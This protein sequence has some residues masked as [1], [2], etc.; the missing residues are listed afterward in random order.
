M[1]PLQAA[2]W[3]HAERGIPTTPIPFMKKG[4]VTPGWNERLIQPHEFAQYFNGERQN[5]SVLTGHQNPTDQRFLADVDIDSIPAFYA[6][7]EYL[8][9]TGMKWGHG[10]M[11][12]T[13]YLYWADEAPRSRKYL[14]PVASGDEACLIELRCRDKGGKYLSTL[15]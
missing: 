9:P 4:S 3:F 11:T 7:I 6:A 13:H 14:D 5:I 12:P 2:E 10:A 8:S 1:K 15:A